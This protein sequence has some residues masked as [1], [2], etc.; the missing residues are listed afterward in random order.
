MDTDQILDLFTISSSE[1]DAARV[2][3][4]AKDGP[5]SQK[6]VLEGLESLHDEREYDSFDVGKFAA[7]LKG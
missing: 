6:N 7:S 5:A 1:D 4:K 3:Q 2:K